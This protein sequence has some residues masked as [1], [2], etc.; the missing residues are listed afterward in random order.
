MK[1]SRAALLLFLILALSLAACQSAASGEPNPNATATPI[2]LVASPVS[3][4]A[5]PVAPTAPPVG[6][7]SAAQAAS[8]APTPTVPPTVVAKE[9]Y[10]KN[11]GAITVAANDPLAAKVNG[12]PIP[13]AQ[14]QRM[15]S[16]EQAALTAQ[17]VDPKSPSGQETLKGLGQQV[18]G[19]LIDDAIVEQAAQQA[20]VSVSDQDVN[21]RI[22]Q[23][24]DDAGGRDKFDAYL[25]TTQLQLDDLCTQIRASIFGEIMLTRETAT[26][27]TKVEQVHSAQILLAS[28]ADADNVLAQLKAGKDFAALAKQYSTD[29]ATRDNGG[30]LGWLPK[31]IM[32]PEFD[33]VAF[34]LQPGQISGVVSTQIGFHIIKL[35]ERDPA[36]ELSPEL[37]QNQRQQAF[38]AWLD[39]Q[40]NKA[41]I[42]KLVNP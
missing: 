25:K 17:G 26:M 40:R 31:G 13:L 28:Q 12:Q 15:V 18:L 27:P 11:G 34:Q 42:E 33:N 8:P 22:Q 7:T 29:E 35:I 14:Y 4:Q 2:L 37:L 1:L 21:N 16:Q 9:A 32:P 39:A 24:I 41:K 23:M 5:S 30:D 10:C 36:R 3:P 20:N 38:L 19:Q 6:A